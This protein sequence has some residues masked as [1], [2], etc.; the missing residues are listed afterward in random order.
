MFLEFEAMPTPDGHRAEPLSTNARALQT[1][2]PGGRGITVAGE[3][4]A[5]VLLR[6]GPVCAH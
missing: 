6:Y 4:Y 1:L 5:Q 2:L 3:P